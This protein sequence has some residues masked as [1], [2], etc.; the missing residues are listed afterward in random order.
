MDH[1]LKSLLVFVYISSL[2][3]SVFLVVDEEPSR[4]KAAPSAAAVEIRW[5][6]GS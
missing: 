2:F 6:E 3:G 1:F 4:A 5:G